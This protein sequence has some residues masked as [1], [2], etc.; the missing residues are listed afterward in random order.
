M[1]RSLLFILVSLMGAPA[2]ANT[3]LQQ[4]P[5]VLDQLQNETLG[6]L[7]TEERQRA[8]QIVAALCRVRTPGSDRNLRT[9]PI[10]QAPHQPGEPAIIEPIILFDAERRSER[11]R[12]DR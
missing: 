7:S 8:E 12:R 5:G 11:P 9:A 10:S 1:K 2:Q 6:E 3:C 4:V